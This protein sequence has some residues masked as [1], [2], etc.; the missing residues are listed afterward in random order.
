MNVSPDDVKIWTVVQVEEYLKL[1]GFGE[2][3]T[4]I[5]R[6]NEIDGESLLLLNDVD[7]A[8]MGFKIGPVAKFRSF[9][10]TLK[11]FPSTST[12]HLW[13]EAL[14]KSFPCLGTKVTDVEG[15]VTMN[16]DIYFHPKAIGFMR[17]NYK[18]C[19]EA[20]E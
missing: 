3:I 14:V 5:L 15:K 13:A 7:V 20:K 6:G 12:Q 8:S 16:H 11:Y 10:V 2:S 18:K 19:V 9:L 17:T 4:N 1:K